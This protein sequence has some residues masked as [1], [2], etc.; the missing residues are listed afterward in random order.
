MLLGRDEAATALGLHPNTVRVHVSELFTRLRVT[1]RWE[2]A[3]ELGWLQDPFGV[4]LQPAGVR[5]RSTLGRPT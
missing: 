5:Y 4:P 3:Y 2:A 1:H